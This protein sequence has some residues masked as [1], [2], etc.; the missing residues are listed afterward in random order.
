MRLQSAP[1]NRTNYY[2]SSG[3]S[4]VRAANQQSQRAA[5]MDEEKKSGYLLLDISKEGRALSQKQDQNS[6]KMIEDLLELK[7]TMKEQKKS[8]T[9]SMKERGCDEQTIKDRIKGIDDNIKMIDVQVRNIKMADH[10]RKLEEA[11][12]NKEKNDENQ[13]VK[14]KD[15]INKTDKNNRLDSN[16]KSESHEQKKL[17]ELQKHEDKNKQYVSLQKEAKHNLTI[18]DSEIKAD[19]GRS[20]TG[21]AAKFKYENYAKMT[22]QY[23]SMSFFL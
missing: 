12:E 2:I 19:E 21:T 20:R 9:E 4:A 8:I 1:N 5:N 6:A 10:K 3:T 22:N 16:K 7:N 23:F 11:K 15:K 18:L 14:D 13:G 17:M